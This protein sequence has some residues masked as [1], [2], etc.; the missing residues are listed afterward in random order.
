VQCTLG[1]VAFG[2]DEEDRAPADAA[3]AGAAFPGE[4]GETT[5]AQTAAT[6]A[7]GKVSQPQLP[8]DF[9]PGDDIER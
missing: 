2:A 1:A 8:L 5:V 9:M 7:G 4:L 3:G 6:R